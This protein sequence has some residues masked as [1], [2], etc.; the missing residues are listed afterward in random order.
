MINS[1]IIPYCFLFKVFLSDF[2]Q[3]NPISDIQIIHDYLSSQY[4][5][6]ERTLNAESFAKPA[7]RFVSDMHKSKKTACCVRSPT[8]ISL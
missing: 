8:S 4:Y 3:I 7:L 5:H 2:I 1:G 6:R